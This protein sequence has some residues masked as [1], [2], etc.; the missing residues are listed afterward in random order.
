MRAYARQARPGRGT[1]GHRRP[2]ARLRLRALARPAGSSA[3]GR[4]N[5]E[6]TR[7][8]GG[9]D[10]RDQVARRL[11]ARLPAGDSAAQGPVRLRRAVRVRDRRGP[12]PAR[13]H[14]RHDGQQREEEDEVEGVRPQRVPRG[15]RTRGGR[16]RRGTDRPHP[17]RHR[18]PEA[19]R[20]GAGHREG[21]RGED[22][23]SRVR[24]IGCT[25]CRSCRKFVRIGRQSWTADRLRPSMQ[26][27]DGAQVEP[28]PPLQVTYN[29]HFRPHARRGAPC[30]SV[31]SRWK[32]GRRSRS[33]RT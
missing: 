23:R 28:H 21:H 22:G 19:A 3:A 6:G 25:K 14:H 2:P 32:G 4:T 15:H 33:P 5:P 29:D 20:G 17:V 12:G 10:L 30:A 13:R 7:L 27:C 1:L 16:L 24:C 11:P 8:P 9:G 31:S 26:G 18:R